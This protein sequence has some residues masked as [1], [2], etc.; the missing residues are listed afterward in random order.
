MSL[1]GKDA[2]GAV[3]AALVALVY[4]ANTQGWWY[5]GNDRWA[6][7][8]M[9]G[10]GFLGCSSGRAFEGKAPKAP[11][12]LLGLLGLAV[13]VLAVVAIVV[14]SHALLLA[15]TIALLALWA[16]STLRHAATPPPHA[17]AGA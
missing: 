11:V 7:V 10:V 3:V 2:G 6:I 1:T 17:A 15:L 14:G 5:L 13:L 9:A 4:A 12:V 16:G 8:T